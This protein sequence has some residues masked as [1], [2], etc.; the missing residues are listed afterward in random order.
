MLTGRAYT[1]D[2]NVARVVGAH[3]I[4][5]TL[6]SRATLLIN[7]PADKANPLDSPRNTL[8]LCK[9]IEVAM[10][11]GRICFIKLMGDKGDKYQLFLVDQTLEKEVATVDDGKT[12]YE[13][14]TF[15]GILASETKGQLDF[16]TQKNGLMPR[17]RFL[18]LHAISAIQSQSERNRTSCLEKA[19]KNGEFNYWNESGED[20]LLDDVSIAALELNDLAMGQADTDD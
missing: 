17:R 10:D 8:V 5:R 13:P 3:I 15:S 4:S 16:S 2:D 11:A 1:N 12:G 6:L 7:L 14:L 18:G 19:P 20:E 9:P